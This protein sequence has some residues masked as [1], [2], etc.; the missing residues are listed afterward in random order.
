MNDSGF[1]CFEDID[2][3]NNYCSKIA[4]NI[5]TPNTSIK[6]LQ[7]LINKINGVSDNDKSNLYKFLHLYWLRGKK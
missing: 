7:K 4:V 6:D 3:I 5:P 1:P 2:Y